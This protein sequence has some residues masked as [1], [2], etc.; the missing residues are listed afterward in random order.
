[1]NPTS[2]RLYESLPAF[3][4]NRDYY[5]IMQVSKSTGWRDIK[6][7]I[8]RGL[9]VAHGKGKGSIYTLADKANPQGGG[10]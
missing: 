3:V 5:E 9:L 7:L 10:A 6:N 8:E 1:M 2:E 4:R